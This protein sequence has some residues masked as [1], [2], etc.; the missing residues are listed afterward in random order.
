MLSYL[1]CELLRVVRARPLV[2]VAVGGDRYS[3]GYSPPGRRL[4]AI[5]LGRDPLLGRSFQAGV[6]L[7]LSWWEPGCSSS[8]YISVSP[9]S[10][11]FWHAAGT[12][13]PLD[14]NPGGVVSQDRLRRCFVRI[15]LPE[16]VR[17]QG[18]CSISVLHSAVLALNHPRFITPEVAG[19]G[20]VSCFDCYA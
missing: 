7:L 14:A 1:P 4:L 17:G 11:P 2:S 13:T 19:H 18:G 12:T 8:A 20:A 16:T 5:G 3:V 9:V 15:G 10:A 6:K